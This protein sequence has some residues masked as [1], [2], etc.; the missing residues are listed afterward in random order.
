MTARDP[1]RARDVR[2]LDIVDALSRKPFEQSVWRVAREG[3]DPVQGSSSA[4]RW[5]NGTFDV[6]YTSLERDGAIAE[7]HSLLSAQPVFPSIPS[8]FAHSLSVSIDKSVVFANL[9]ELTRFG[10]EISRYRERDYRRTQEIAD[11]AFFLGF[12]GMLVPSARWSCLN[13]VVFTDRVT[14]EKVFIDQSEATSIKWSERK[15]SR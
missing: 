5:C 1:R 4:S 8:W 11:A 7:V 15:K 10:V 2:L 12:D 13:A 9:A 14:P 3:R 6:L